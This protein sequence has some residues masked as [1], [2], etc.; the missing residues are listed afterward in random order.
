M[1]ANTAILS[2]VDTGWLRPLP[3]DD[4]SALVSLWL[5]DPAETGEERV[6]LT[7]AD[8]AD[9][10]H[11]PGLFAAVSGWEPTTPVLTGVDAAE[12][13][14][15][16]AVTEG[17]FSRVLR[18][19]PLLGRTFLPDE[20][21]PDAAPAVVL[22][23]GFW[24]E[25]FGGDPEAIGRSVVLDGVPH[26]VVG[27]MT[28]DFHPPFRSDAHLWTPAGLS[29]ER[30]RRDCRALPAIARLAP[31]TTLPV[32]RDRATALTSRLAESH[33]ETNAG[34]T[35]RL[36]PLG[37]DRSTLSAESMR[38]LVLA[39]LLVLVIT[40]ANVAVLLVVRGLERVREMA[41]RS[42]VGATGMAMIRHLVKESAAL[43]LV[44]G[45][46]GVG[47][48]VW[49]IEGLERLAPSGLVGV[50]EVEVKIGI[51]LSAMGLAVFVG[52]LSGVVP[53]WLM[54]RRRGVPVEGGIR[55]TTGQPRKAHGWTPAIVVTE[56][57]LAV[58]LAV[59]AGSVAQDLRTATAEARG[60]RSEGLLTMTVTLP[61]DRYRDPPRRLELI[62][63]LSRELGGMP[64]T[65]SVG[66]T[67]ALPSDGSEILRPV[68]VEG[69]VADA[70]TPPRRARVRPVSEEYFYTMGQRMAE[71]RGFRDADGATAEPVAVLDATAARR[72][73]ADPPRSP[74]GSRLAMGEV[75]G[76]VWRT[77]VGVVD[78]APGDGAEGGPVVYVPLAQAPAERPTFVVRVDD[79]PARYVDDARNALL[80]VDPTLAAVRIAPLRDIVAE[81]HAGE[82]FA[83]V[84]SS[85]FAVLALLLSVVGLYGVMAHGVSARLRELGLRKAVGATASDLRLSV[86]GRAGGL[87]AL[88]VVI[89]SVVAGFLLRGSGPG[90]PLWTTAATP[91]VYAG[92][93][94][95][96]ALAALLG[97]LHPMHRSGS[98]D[99][100]ATLGRE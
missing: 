62:E 88:G 78:D 51:L 71:G 55:L 23:H 44:G 76:I 43:A 2:V 7:G 5:E 53:A 67:G 73:F 29:A 79:D 41:I 19:Q 4:A 8:M 21:R 61:A 82:R 17:M 48:A 1:G 12:V 32:A 54:T 9:L 69:E 33:P 30:C 83:A 3:F 10:R 96:V 99:A 52:V 65:F 40:C 22:S 80:D 18:V 74:V 38:A 16:A 31:G 47:M 28:P 66:V 87:A 42:S 26:V 11:E 59:G 49:G 34:I 14:T 97:A 58:V 35:A 95:L 90:L 86:L 68:M 36:A 64:G 25:R 81:A 60:V 56:V 24:S 13:V 98:V 100:V 72:L 6:P 91:L 85:A 63:A 92:V 20:D 50:R 57:A 27:V 93:L 37:R 70:S 75:P 46:L 89:G 94:T 77:V 15:G 84:L 45:F 39:G